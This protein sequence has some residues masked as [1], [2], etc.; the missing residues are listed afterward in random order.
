MAED[1]TELAQASQNPIANLISVPFENNLDF[2]VGP[3][4]GEVYVLNLKPVVPV[5]LGEW[6]LIN[7][8][9]I[10]VSHQEERFANEGSETGLG[11]ATYQAFFTPAQ[12]GGLLWGVGPALT[13]PTNT[14][15][16]LGTDKW[17][18]GP[19]AVLVKKAGPWLFGSLLSQAWSFAGDSDENNVN[20]SS[21]QYFINYNFSNGWYLSSTPTMTANWDADSDNRFTVPVGGGAGKIVRFG[22]FPVDMKLQGFYNAEKPDGAATWSIQFQFKLLFPK[23]GKN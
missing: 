11:N 6:N 23:R 14:D 22:K 20:L 15:D 10:P 8:F 9:I 5:N 1:E 18:A 16:R 17:S 21:W 4:D 2:N 3:E 19:A 7:R 13:V 12:P